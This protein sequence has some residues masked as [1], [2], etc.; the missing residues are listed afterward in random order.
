M[1]VCTLALTFYCCTD[2]LMMPPECDSRGET[3]LRGVTCESH[4]SLAEEALYN[5]RK[6]PQMIYAAAPL[7]QQTFQSYISCKIRGRETLKSL[8]GHR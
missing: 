7:R 4:R 8:P 1:S 6:L 3:M 5:F 2:I